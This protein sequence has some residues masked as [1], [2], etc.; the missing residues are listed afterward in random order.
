M[1]SC[2]CRRLAYLGLVAN[3]GLQ[4]SE[5]AIQ[6]SQNQRQSTPRVKPQSG[7]SCP[8]HNH[9]EGFSGEEQERFCS[10]F[11]PD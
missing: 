7:V 1:S 2:H 6:I 10:K 9:V 8:N 4:A 5:V 11:A 3:R